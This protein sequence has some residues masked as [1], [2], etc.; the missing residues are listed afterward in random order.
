MKRR[1]TLTLLGIVL[2]SSAVG[3][4]TTTNGSPSASSTTA[5]PALFDP[6][7]EVPDDALRAAGVDPA[8]KEAG[9]AGV[10]QVGLEVCKWRG[11]AY[12]ISLY[13][14]GKPVSEFETKPGNIGFQDVTIAGRQ[15]REFRA[16]GWETQCNAVFP[17]AQG[18]LQVQ[19]LG[20]M[21]V[22]NP[23]DPCSVLA[24]VGE[25]IVPILPK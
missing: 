25:K 21:S 18:A 8:T 4:G 12:A 2:A 3:C 16:E 22:D 19:I 9:I 24:R 23:E 5:A 17:A 20:R 13:S 7:T 15:G 10:H 11:P 6:C 14:T 1:I